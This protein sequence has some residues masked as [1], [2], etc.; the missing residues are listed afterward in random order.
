MFL[1]ILK[2]S[3]SNVL[4]MFLNVILSIGCLLFSI[5]TNRREARTSFI[6][7]TATQAGKKEKRL[8]VAHTRAVVIND[9]L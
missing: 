6:E 9:Y 7:L 8:L 2:N 3:A 5:R 1:N 4:E